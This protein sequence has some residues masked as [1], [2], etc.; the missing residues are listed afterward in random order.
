MTPAFLTGWHALDVAFSAA[1]QAWLA[2]V[3][4]AWDPADLFRVAPFRLALR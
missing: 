2:K 4:Q 3:K 1:E